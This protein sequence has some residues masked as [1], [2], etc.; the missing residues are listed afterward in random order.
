MLKKIA[1]TGPES[2]GKTT[3]CLALASHF[4]CRFVPEMARVILEKE[5]S[6]YDEKKVEEM[7]R[8]QIQ[9]E[10]RLEKLARNAEEPFLFCDT[11]LLVYQVW[12]EVR[13]GHCPGWIKESVENADYDLQLLMHPD[14]PWE[15]DPLRENPL[16]R[17][18]LF[19]RYESILK[20][21][22]GKWATVE[23]LGHSRFTYS[24]RLIEQFQ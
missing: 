13:F 20:N 15:A 17:L 22:N 5:G 23:G 14:L 24:L 11:N 18:A 7:A 16:D 21:G 3:L 10:I 4:K 2:S 12:M 19:H 8:R 1:L 6:S 9:E